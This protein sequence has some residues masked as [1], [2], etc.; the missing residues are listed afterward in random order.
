METQNVDVPAELRA[1]VD[2]ALVWLNELD[3]ERTRPLELTGLVD[4]ESALN[5]KPEEPHEFG[6]VLCD[7]EICA[8]E[9][10]RVVPTADGFSFSLVE[11]QVSEIPPLLDPPEGVRSQWLDQ[12]LASHEF[13]VFLFYRGLW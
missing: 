12:V 11:Q 6:L 3:P 13:V 5:A 4:F 1:Q 10:V 7:G 9:Q 2:G 8:R